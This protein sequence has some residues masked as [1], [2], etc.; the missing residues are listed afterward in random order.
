MAYSGSPPFSC[1]V[2]GAD[3]ATGEGQRPEAFP[4]CSRR[5]RQRDLGA[6]LDGRYAIAG[7]PVDQT[8]YGDEG[9]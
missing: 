2:C 9:L 5:C 3:V 7:R 1:P 8:G 6:W 4:F